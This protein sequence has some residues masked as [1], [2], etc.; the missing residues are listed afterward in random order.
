[1]TRSITVPGWDIVP[2]PNDSSVPELILVLVGVSDEE[3]H[4]T[5]D[6]IHPQ[7]L[8]VMVE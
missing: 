1:L 3:Y 4:F 8:L 7:L 2:K 5:L 6:E